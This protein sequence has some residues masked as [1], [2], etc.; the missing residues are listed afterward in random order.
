MKDVTIAGMLSDFGVTHPEAQGSAVEALVEAGVLSGRPNR[1]RISADKRARVAD[2]LTEAF[3]RHC[4]NGDC[5]QQAATRPGARRLLLVDRQHCEVCGGSANRSALERMADPLR[6]RGLSRVLVVGGT[7]V[8]EREIRESSPG[9]VEWRF[10][11]TKVAR[12]DR[13]Y[14][15]GRDWAEVTVVWSSTPL[16]HKVSRHFEDGGGI[17]VTVS[18]RGVAALADGVREHVERLST[19]RPASD[20]G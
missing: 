18:R 10:V 9:Y 1:T 3:L 8:G 20:G 2:V 7:E 16:P 15:S 14:R 6:N 17:R 19:G 5:R 11:N 13:Y 4:G 12:D